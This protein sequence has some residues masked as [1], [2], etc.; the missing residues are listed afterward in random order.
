[1]ADILDEMKDALCVAILS[2]ESTDISVT[3][4]LILYVRFISKDFDVKS[5]FVGNFSI[6]E[7]DATTITNKLTTA[8]A[9]RGIPANKI[10]C[11]G[12]DGASVMTGM[13]NGVAAQLKRMSPFL[14]NIHCVAH[15]LAL[16]TSQ[17]ASKVDVMQQYKSILTSLYY[18]FKSSSVRSSR[19]A[20][21]QNLFDQP[22]I[23]MKE[24]HDIRWFSF[25]NVL[26]GIYKSWSALI[27]YFD[28]T[29]LSKD[30]KAT[31]LRKSL[32]Q[33]KFPAMTWYLMDII[34]VITTLNLVFQKDSLDVSVIKPIVDTTISK[35]EYLKSNDGH[36]KQEFKRLLKGDT[37]FDHGLS[38]K[39]QQ[40][41][42]VESAMQTFINNLIEN[43]KK[44]FPDD[45]ISVVS[46]FDA[47]AMRDLSFVPTSQIDAYGSDKLDVLLDYY[48]K[49][50]GVPEVPEI[51]DAKATR[52]EYSLLK[53]LVLQQRYLRDK[54]AVLWKIIFECHKEQFQNLLKLA[55][56]ALTLPVQTAIC[57][58]GF[59]C[60]NNIKTA[61]RN[62]LNESSLQTLMTISIEGPPL[63]SFDAAKVLQEF[64]TKKQ[65]RIFRK[66][67][68]DTGM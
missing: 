9:E 29:E 54:L 28:S 16:C 26:E 21:I 59:S 33:Y 56:I 36:Y 34:P 49:P 60:Q 8:L 51:V 13:N 41:Q 6:G 53:P 46:A 42:L 52:A 58:R 2:D 55:S 15:R 57:E 65:R 14:I 18:Y 22:Q 64:K 44:R 37:L 48:S 25:Y 3:G 39:T 47:L 62:R 20:E 68:F 50:R 32:L 12:S 24:M 66:L 27:I 63:R 31:G 43:M 38:Y 1:M 4:K 35:L 61:H 5:H 23:K 67:S 11:L 45:S 40:E 7:K 19:L 10:L 17:A 30:P